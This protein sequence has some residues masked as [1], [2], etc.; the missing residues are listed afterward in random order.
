MSKVIGPNGK[1]VFSIAI[2]WSNDGKRYLET[3]MVEA[4]SRA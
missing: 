4:L 2:C 3:T 1:D